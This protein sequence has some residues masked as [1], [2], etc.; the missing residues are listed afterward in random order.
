MCTFCNADIKFNLILCRL[1]EL[2]I[3]TNPIIQELLHLGSLNEI[4]HTTVFNGFVEL[5]NKVVGVSFVCI[6]VMS[7]Y[8]FLFV[9]NFF[10]FYL[11][12]Y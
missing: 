12:N 5:R 6:Y 10:C 2:T 3:A 8:S 1:Y 4:L 11:R 7:F 9:S